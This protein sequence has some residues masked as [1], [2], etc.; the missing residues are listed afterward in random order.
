MRC[1]RAL[2]IQR[3]FLGG[4]SRVKVSRCLLPSLSAS[5]PLPPALLPLLRCCIPKL[6]AKVSATMEK[7][8]DELEQRRRAQEANRSLMVCTQL[9]GMVCEETRCAVAVTEVA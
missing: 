4:R 9:R 6:M 2:D 3:S 5:L 8:A 1:D 7:L